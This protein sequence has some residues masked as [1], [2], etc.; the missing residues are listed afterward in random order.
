MIPVFVF[1]KALTQCWFVSI[2][3]SKLFYDIHFSLLEHVFVTEHLLCPGTVLSTGSTEMKHVVPAIKASNAVGR[4]KHEKIAV[5][6]KGTL[7][8]MVCSGLTSQRSAHL[9]KPWFHR[10]DDA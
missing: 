6:I 8:E 4:K 9:R 10:V 7:Q 2:A 1:F 5:D 3:P